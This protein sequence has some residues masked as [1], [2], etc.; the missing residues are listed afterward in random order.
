MS[1]CRE[2]FSH[3]I[4]NVLACLGGFALLFWVGFFVLMIVRK[5]ARRPS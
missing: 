4:I 2:Q 1:A 5:I 3:L